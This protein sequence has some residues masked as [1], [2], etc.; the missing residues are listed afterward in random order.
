[1]RAR[2]IDAAA[3]AFAGAVERSPQRTV[4]WNEWA[5]LYLQLGYYSEGFAMLDR[6]LRLDDR[7]DT[8][9][10]LRAQGRMTL[11]DVPGA[12]ADFERAAELRPRSPMAWNGQAVALTRLGRNGEA[13]AAARRAFALAPD[14]PVIR[15]TLAALE[16]AGSSK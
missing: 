8:T 15:R 14:D 13:L 4:V 6:S 11:G 3:A 2:H 12:L 7:Y 9:Y 16:D 10:L 1:M 5:A